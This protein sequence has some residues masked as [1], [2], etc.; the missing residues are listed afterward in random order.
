MTQNLETWAVGAH[1]FSATWESFWPDGEESDVVWWSGRAWV[2]KPHAAHY[3]SQ[4]QADAVAVELVLRG[5]DNV[6]SVRVVKV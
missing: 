4:E 3:P 6:R 5:V 2:R 1:V